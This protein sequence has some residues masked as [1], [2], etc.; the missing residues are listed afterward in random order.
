MSLQKFRTYL[1]EF[2]ALTIVSAGFAQFAF[3]GKIEVA[4][5]VDTESREVVLDRIA[6]TLAREDVASQMAAYGVTPADVQARLRGLSDA[7]LVELDGRLGEEI[8]G[9]DTLAVIGTVFL[10]L[11]ILELV[12]VTDIFKSI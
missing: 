11:L 1:V 10:V 2:L 9:G 5:V 12:G 4:Q 8:A 6:V 7:E 3:A